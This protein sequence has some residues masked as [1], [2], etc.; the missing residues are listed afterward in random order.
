L[1]TA[2]HVTRQGQ[3][4]LGESEQTFPQQGEQAATDSNE[5][6]L[7]GFGPYRAPRATSCRGRL[8]LLQRMRFAVADFC[9]RGGP[10]KAEW[11]VGRDAD[12]V[13]GDRRTADQQLQLDEIDAVGLLQKVLESFSRAASSALTALETADVAV[14]VT[15]RWARLAASRMSPKFTI[16]DTVP[17]S[18]LVG[19]NWSVLEN[20][21]ASCFGAMPP[22]G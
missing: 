7:P 19:P 11:Q 6:P 20:L 18:S 13:R 14:A 10:R 3:P 16:R 17:S 2:E 9:L 8:A 4:R 21:Q 22:G 15:R 1:G 12:V 5:Q